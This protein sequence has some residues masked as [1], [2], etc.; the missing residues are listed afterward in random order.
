M[1][2]IEADEVEKQWK[3]SW[4]LK[5]SRRPI[6]GWS[7]HNE[8]CFVHERLLRTATR[9]GTSFTEVQDKGIEARNTK[10]LLNKEGR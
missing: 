1:N 2:R 5:V 10:E 7:Y 4:L 6:R 9:D 3:A 8:V